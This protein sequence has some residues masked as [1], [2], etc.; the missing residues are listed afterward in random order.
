MMNCKECLYHKMCP[1]NI[2]GAEAEQCKTYEN[3]TDYVKVVRCKDCIY[4]EENGWCIIQAS[5]P[6]DDEYCSFGDKRGVNQQ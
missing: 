2:T 3:A 5:Y 4:R 6:R 1:F